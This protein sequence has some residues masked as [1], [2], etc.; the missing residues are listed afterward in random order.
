MFSITLHRS[1][2][3][4]GEKSAGFQF[5]HVNQTIGKQI[6]QRRQCL[7]GGQGKGSHSLCR[8]SLPVFGLVL[9]H[10]RLFS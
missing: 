5:V 2:A 1:I 9:S 7:S 3:L 4:W 10:C 8:I 6:Y